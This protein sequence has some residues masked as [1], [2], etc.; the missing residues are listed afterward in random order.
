MT[1]PTNITREHLI[2]AFEKIDLDGVP[3]GA[4]SKY[5]DVI[6]N[7]KRYPPKY[8]ISVANIFA[9]NEQLDRNSFKGGLGTECFKVLEKNGF[10]I[11]EKI[12]FWI[13]KTKL[14]REDRLKGDWAMGKALW[15]PRKSKTEADIYKNMKLVKKGDVVLHLVNDKDFVGISIVNNSAIETEGIKN[16]DWDGPAYFISLEQYEELKPPINRKELLNEQNKRVLLEIKSATEVFYTRNLTL[17]QG[18][19]LTPCPNRLLQLINEIYKINTNLN[20]PNLEDIEYMDEDN[21]TNLTL[22]NK[23]YL[24]FEKVH[25]KISKN[26][27]TRFACSLITKRL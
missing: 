1:L 7:E 16:T 19:Y 4:H 11:I 5:Y 18:A 10:T 23:M 25:F 9:N 20:L 13:E 24:D 17:R 14:D 27:L 22:L 26:L 15:S 6:Y 12:R 21:S 2:K 8:V 3:S